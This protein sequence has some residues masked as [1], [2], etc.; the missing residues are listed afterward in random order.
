M[1]KQIS[2]VVLMLLVS[3]AGRAQ[4]NEESFI[5]TLA[6]HVGMAL[7]DLK[8]TQGI[9]FGGRIGFE[10]SVSDKMRITANGGSVTYF[11]KKYSLPGGYTEKYSP[12]ALMQIT[13]GL[14][15][16]YYG[17][18]FGAVQAGLTGSPWNSYTG[19]GYTYSPELGY[20]FGDDRFYFIS[21]R[22]DNNIIKGK[23]G[24]GLI[25]SIGYE[26]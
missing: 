5:V 8:S 2:A 14:K 15:Y 18:L 13:G 17:G 20:E 26:F 9:A 24:Q 25:F 1:K 10:F 3:L 23:N 12:Y 4:A 21:L 19:W 11:G 16:F 6:P 7:G 22:Y